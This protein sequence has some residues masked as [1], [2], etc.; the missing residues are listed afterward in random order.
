MDT[1]M[2]S[3]TGSERD[4]E[5]RGGCRLNSRTFNSGLDRERARIPLGLSKDIRHAD[6]VNGDLVSLKDGKIVPLDASLPFSGIIESV[7]EDRGKYV[8]SVTTRGAIVVRVVGLTPA[9]REG[10]KIYALPGTRTVFTLESKGV[11]IGEFLAAE[12]MEREMAIV[13][14][15]VP[16]DRRR[17]EMNR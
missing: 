12:S 16:S 7:A 5:L 9:T 4:N 6:L 1:M 3:G 15:R 17:F 8:A 11:E 2:F 10:S 14:V 13:G